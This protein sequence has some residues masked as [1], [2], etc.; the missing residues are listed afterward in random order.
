MT[1]YEECLAHVMAYA[2]Y[3]R[4]SDVNPSAIEGLIRSYVDQ[5]AYDYI[6]REKLIREVLYETC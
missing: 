6:F 1:R 3:L 4:L 2:T 5:P